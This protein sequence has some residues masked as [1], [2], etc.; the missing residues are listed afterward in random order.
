MYHRLPRK[1][2]RQRPIYLVHYEAS[3]PTNYLT[4]SQLSSPFH[5]LISKQIEGFHIQLSGKETACLKAED[6]GFITGSSDS[7]GEGNSNPL[8]YSCLENPMDRGTCWVS[9]Q[10]L[11]KESD[12]T[13]RLKNSNNSKQ[14]EYYFVVQ[15][16][17]LEGLSKVYINNYDVLR[18]S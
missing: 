7:S 3:F 6:Q 9:V 18:D 12:M 8:P 16:I 10:G 17:C 11:V 15:M 4:L 14:V 13:Q 1:D 2:N 5:L